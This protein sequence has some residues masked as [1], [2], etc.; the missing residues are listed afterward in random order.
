MSTYN[1]EEP[2][3]QSAKGIIVIFGVSAFKLVKGLFIVIVAFLLKYLQSDKGPDLSHPKYL[4]GAMGLVLFFL[5]LAVLRYL[6]FKF[7]IKED[8]FFLEKGILNK[9]EVSVSFSKIQNVYIKQ[10]LLQQIINVV[11][12][13]IETAG[14]DKTEIEILA[15][16]KPKADDLKKQLLVAARVK[17]ETSAES[18]EDKIYFKASIKRLLLEGISENHL[19]SFVLIFAFLTS[20]YNDLQEFVNQFDFTTRFREWFRLDSES[21]MTLILFNVTII[22]ALLI[23]SFLFSLVKMFIQNFDLTVTRKAQGLEISKGLFNKINLG[24]TSSR[25]QT[26][27]V[28]TNRLKKVL[29]LYKLSFTQAMANKKQ[30]QNF[31]IVGLNINQID[32]LVGQF[33][34]DVK[35]RIV[36]RKPN[37]Y[38]AYRILWISSFIVSLINIG[39]YFLPGWFL[40]LNLPLL[41]FI[42]FNT[43]FTYK[44]S[45]Y[46]LDKDYIVVGGGALI[47]TYTSYLEVHKIRAITMKQTIFQ[48]RRQLASLQVFSA[49]RSIT[50][51][52]IDI[53]TALDIKNYLLYLVESGN[54]DWM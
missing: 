39:L 2:S 43:Y 18:E 22:V 36:R 52:Q 54:K 41:V 53:N 50:I 28:S 42:G 1:F 4:L 5:A 15:L 46:H 14:D 17:Q 47:E 10:N 12:L 9:E 19:K 51:P 16:Q 11:S 29:G 8:H 45:Y 31:N 20:I 24:L 32:E 34:P 23:V 38:L 48:K 44:K 30:Q 3:R 7:Y 26:T 13:S 27:T 35:N 25:I 37:R 6:N 40:L 21:F 33:Y 49:S